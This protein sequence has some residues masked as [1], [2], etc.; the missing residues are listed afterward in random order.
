MNRM[1]DAYDKS[2]AILSMIWTV[3]SVVM[4]CEIIGLFVY[5]IKFRKRDIEKYVSFVYN[6][7]I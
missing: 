5:Y 3:V 2:H 6:E 1:G 7:C 4:V